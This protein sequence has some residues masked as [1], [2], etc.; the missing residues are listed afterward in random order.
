MKHTSIT[1]TRLRLVLSG[2]F[3]ALLAIGVAL[4]M[5]GYN[6]LADKMNDSRVIAAEAQASNTSLQNLMA[7]EK[8]LKENQEAVE[9]SS[10]IVAESQMY[11]YQDQI[12]TDLYNFAANAQLSIENI[13]FTDATATPTTPNS[14]PTTATSGAGAQAS[15]ASPAQVAPSGIK[16]VTATITVKNPVNYNAM[17]TFLHSIE[18]SLFKMRVSQVSLSKTADDSD[19]TEVTSDSLTIEVYIK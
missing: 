2:L 16:S 6:I 1:P 8:A 10:Q 14:G 9:R 19:A 15:G 17:L 5:F 4:F 11:S 7:I 13:S 12:I 3:I 18:S